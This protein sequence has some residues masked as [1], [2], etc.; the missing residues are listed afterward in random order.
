MEGLRRRKGTYLLVGTIVTFGLLMSG[1]LANAQD[2][3]FSATLLQG[4]GT[5]NQSFS[6]SDPFGLSTI[7]VTSIGNRTLSSS[8]SISS[9]QSGLWTIFLVGTGGRT[10]ADLSFGVSP[11]SGPAA[12]IDIGS[13]VSFGWGIGYILILDAENPITADAPLRWTQSISGAG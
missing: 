3:F 10:W 11:F 2:N 13:G 1:N 12:A 5:G 4:Q 7:A 8:L 6:S 9:G